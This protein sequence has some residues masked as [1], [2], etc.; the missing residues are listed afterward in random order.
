MESISVSEF[1][2]CARSWVEANLEPDTDPAPQ[3]K[4][5]EYY[6][7]EVITKNRALQRKIY[8]AGY[9]GI[10]IPKRYGGRGLTPEHARAFSEATAGYVLP[11]FGTS[12]ITTWRIM[13]PTLLAHG[14][15][16]LLRFIIPQILRGDALI[17]QFLSEPS[18]GSDLAGIRTRAT[19]DGDNWDI[20]GQKTWTTYAQL[21]DWGLC[22]ARTNWDAHKHHGMTWFLVPVHDQ[23]VTIR[24]IRQITGQSSYCDSFFDHLRIPDL[25]RVGEVD[26]GWRTVT[27][28]WM[29]Y[30]RS[31]GNASAATLDRGLSSAV[32][33][34]RPGPLYPI[35]A[36]LAIG[37]G[38]NTDPR[39]RQQVART[40]CMVYATRALHWRLSERA[41]L[42]QMTPGLTAYGKLIRG[43]YSPQIAR[44]CMEIG[45]AEALTWES[46]GPEVG[47]PH[48]FQYLDGRHAA[49]S[50]GTNEITRNLISE[51]MLGLPREP[52]YDSG[53]PYHEVVDTL[54]RGGV[55][56]PINARSSD[57]ADSTLT[58][59]VSS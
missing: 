32:E 22:L 50:G 34:P 33:R 39:V 46:N 35:A 37:A 49:I 8:D 56:R 51:Q 47:S 20:D 29:M 13:T 44:L 16:A 3:V 36:D 31:A 52:S 18:S 24:P 48:V 1:R 45:G 26:H 41:R 12:T 11:D 30:E 7:P 58:G 53:R 15:P 54:A 10:S 19:R 59:E 28:T 2:A 6:T 5:V 38:R 43:T 25:Y 42:G 27:R 9:S 57:Q 21:A 55:L 14:T 17:C 23:K 40:H 4:P